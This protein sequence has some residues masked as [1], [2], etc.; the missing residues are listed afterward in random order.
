[1]APRE[2]LALGDAAGAGQATPASATPC[3]AVAIERDAFADHAAMPSTRPMV[4]IPTRE[5]QYWRT[6]LAH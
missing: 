6:W 1:V 3:R 2:L 5:C 4:M